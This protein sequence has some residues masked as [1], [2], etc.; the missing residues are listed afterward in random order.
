MERPGFEADRT[1]LA[2]YDRTTKQTRRITAELDRSVDFFTWSADSR[3]LWFLAQ[4]ELYHSVYRVA[5]DGSAPVQVTDDA[6]YSALAVSRDGRTLVVARQSV[7]RPVDLFVL[8]G[9]G[10]EQRQLTNQNGALLA[11]LALQ[12]VEEFWFTGADN[13]RVQGFIVRPPNFDASQKY[14]VV[15]LIH[16]G[17]QGAWTDSWSY[18]WN[19]NQFAAPGYVVVAV[20]PRGSTG[21]GQQFTD[22]IT[23]DWG[24]RVY[25]DLM[26]GLDS[27]LATYPFLDKNRL[28]AAGASYGGYMINW[29]NG[30]SDRFRAL[31][32]HDG[33][34]DT[35]SMYFATEELWFPEWEFGGTPWENPEGFD[36]WNPSNHVAS[37]NT[38]TLIIHGGLDYRVPL[39]QGIA[40]FTALR[41]RDV[42]ARL[43]YFPDEGHWVLKPQ[44]AFVWWDTMLDW[45]DAYLRD[46][47]AA[48]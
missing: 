29:I 47:N 20:N 13:A 28:A 6:Y 4:D 18:R 22:E 8:D 34:F 38:P 12:P 27:A 15:Y 41:R 17:P 35:R 25:A 1:Q 5:L 31:I 43:L 32:N 42:P 37:M 2:I 39:E 26:N 3:T 30:H 14:P 45:L 36:R 10:R 40:T 16:G 7:A 48:E 19:P 33:L 11:Q 44:N 24:G 21:Y 23:Q 46:R 9:R